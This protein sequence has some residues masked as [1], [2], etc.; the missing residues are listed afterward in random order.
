MKEKVMMYVILLMVVLLLLPACESDLYPPTDAPTLSNIVLTSD[1]YRNPTSTVREGDTVFVTVDVSDPEN[2]PQLLNL[3]ILS[4]GSP[5]LTEEFCSSCIATDERSWETWFDSSSLSTGPYSVNLQAIDSDGNT[6]DSISKNFDITSDITGNIL[7]G[8]IAIALLPGTENWTPRNTST[9][10]PFT[11]DFTV[12]NNFSMAVD[13]VRFTIN[14]QDNL[15]ATQHSGTAVA[16]SIESGETKAGQLR[17]N[18]PN[19]N[20]PDINGGAA[21]ADLISMEIVIY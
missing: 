8:D 15:G 2:D 16:T 13:I 11:V 17:L 3:Q 10:E 12:T 5:V 6:S 1:S 9:G 14:I 18:I 19:V 4:G 7:P 20:D 21:V